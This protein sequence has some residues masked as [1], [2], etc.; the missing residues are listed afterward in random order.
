MSWYKQKT[1]KSYIILFSC[2]RI[3]IRDLLKGELYYSE[4]F[5][6]SS[7]VSGLIVDKEN[8]LENDYLYVFGK[9]HIYILDLEKKIIVKDIEIKSGLIGN[10]IQWNS[11]YII[12]IDKKDKTLKII[13]SAKKII[14]TEIKLIGAFGDIK[15]LNHPIYGESLLICGEDIS[16]WTI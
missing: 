9:Q 14:V 13:D 8:D 16:L 5:K 2:D 12:V 4:E 3:V 7:P 11:K 10:I 1:N 6:D 15:K